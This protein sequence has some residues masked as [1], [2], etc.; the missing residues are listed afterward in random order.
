MSCSLTSRL[1]APHRRFTL[2]GRNIVTWLS[3]YMIGWVLKNNELLHNILHWFIHGKEM[4]RCN[5]L[6]LHEATV[7][8]L[9]VDSLHCSRLLRHE[10]SS[11]RALHLVRSVSVVSVRVGVQH[12]GRAL[13]QKRPERI[14]PRVRQSLEQRRLRAEDAAGAPTENLQDGRQNVE[15]VRK[16]LRVGRP[17]PAKNPKSQKKNPPSNTENQTK[18]AKNPKSQKSSSKHQNQTCQKSKITKNPPSNTEEQTKPAKRN[19]LP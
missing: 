4:A 8:V 19:S 1:Q 15:K 12:S 7:G 11:E 18:P 2:G 9:E 6:A 16:H 3:P 10:R 14:R 13:T 17:K 5:L